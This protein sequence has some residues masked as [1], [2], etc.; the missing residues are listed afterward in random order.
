VSTKKNYYKALI[1]GLLLTVNMTATIYYVKTAGAGGS[2]SNPGT[3]GS[4][5]LTINKG[6]TVANAGDSVVVSAGNYGAAILTQKAG[7][8]SARITVRAAA[9]DSVIVTVGGSYIN[10]A[11]ITFENITFG[12]VW[13]TS[14][15]LRILSNSGVVKNCIFRDNKENAIEVNSPA[16]NNL[17]EDCQFYNIL[18]YDVNVGN[19][20]AHAITGNNITNLTI[21]G[22][23]MHQIS[24]DALQFD[25]DRL[26]PPWSN[27]L[28]EDCTAYLEPLTTALATASGWNLSDV[29]KAPGENFVDTKTPG[30]N[31]STGVSV[32]W[33]TYPRSKLTI[34]NCT[35]YGYKNG[36][37]GAGDMSA[38]NIK[39]YVDCTIERSTIYDCYIGYRLRYPAQVMVTNSVAFSNTAAVRY[40]D[41]IDN[42]HIYNLTFGKSNTS[43]IIDGGGSGGSLTDFQVRNCLFLGSKPA[44]GSHSSNLTTGSASFVNTTTND[45]HLVAGAAAIDAGVTLVAVTTDRDGIARAQGNAYD[46]GA[47]EWYTGIPTGG[48][49]PTT[50]ATAALP[51]ILPL[52]YPN[53]VNFGK[54]GTFKLIDLPDGS[55]VNIYHIAGGKIRSLNETSNFVEWDGTNDGGEPVSRGIYIYVV[56]APDGRKATGK[57]ATLR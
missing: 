55:V 16:T 54:G 14:R 46:V 33:G 5:F 29:G 6:L 23:T 19:R 50:P 41:K 32:P 48:T 45:Y 1:L 40:E 49:T 53:P 37:G 52:G 47:Y 11:Y 27:I 26:A 2:D 38:F 7:T 17:I 22:C 13:G 10:H 20:D 3:S 57:I 25:P 44:A 15:L 51:P 12:T 34:R 9:G 42:L 24:G 35:G 18:K 43:T 21:R 56:K 28:M 30:P 8:S 36:A 4:P 31:L 39:E